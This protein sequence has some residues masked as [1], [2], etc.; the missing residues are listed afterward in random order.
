MTPN[1]TNQPLAIT[2]WAD[3]CVQLAPDSNGFQLSGLCC[4]YIIIPPIRINENRQFITKAEYYAFT[5][6]GYSPT[7]ATV[8]GELA[9]DGRTLTITYSTGL[10]TRSLRMQPGASTV[11]CLCGC[12]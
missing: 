2:T 11:L 10:I 7:S 5:G 4:A 12:N 9:V 1:Q 6:A 3:G 8:A